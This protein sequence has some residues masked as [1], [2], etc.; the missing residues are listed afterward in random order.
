MLAEQI[1][2]KPGERWVPYLV[3]REKDLHLGRF[4]TSEL[5]P[6]LNPECDPTRR[7]TGDGAP[8]GSPGAVH[9][10]VGPQ[11][12]VGGVGLLQVDEEVLAH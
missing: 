1:G 11:Y 9:A 5:R 8:Q 4:L 3:A 6:S 7:V 10:Q 2:A 12:P